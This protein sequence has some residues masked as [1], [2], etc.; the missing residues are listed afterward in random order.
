M[1]ITLKP[2]HLIA[3]AFLLGS[4]LSTVLVF[5]VLGGGNGDGQ[6]ASPSE[7]S[8]SDHRPALPPAAPTDQP[9]APSPVPPT[10][11]P[12]TAAPVAPTEAPTKP[13]APPPPPPPPTPAAAPVAIGCSVSIP[14]FDG[15]LTVGRP[16]TATARFTCDGAPVSGTP[17]VFSVS[18]DLGLQAY[19]SASTSSSGSASCQVVVPDAD[20]WL[21]LEVCIDYRGR[22]YCADATFY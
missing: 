14:I 20:E 18:S 5:L 15:T 19:C 2:I 13:P 11:V 9:P 16:A 1:T 21:Y 4:V 8:T 7:P 17:M 3:A 22:V 6:K 12:P 10:E